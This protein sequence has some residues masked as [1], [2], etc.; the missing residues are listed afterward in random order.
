MAPKIF[1][2]EQDIEELANQGVTI[3]PL[4]DDVVYTEL[5]LEK[6]RSLGLKLAADAP[7]PSASPRPVPQAVNPPPN[8]LAGQVKA[9]IIAKVGYDVPADVLDAVIPRVL[10][11][12]G[13]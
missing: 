10:A 9:A 1:Y 13:Y 12:L 11:K 8:D 7:A 6:A 4:N 5:A 3:L 2:T